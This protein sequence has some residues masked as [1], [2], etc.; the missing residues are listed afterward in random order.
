[1]SSKKTPM[2]TKQTPAAIS[3]VYGE[4]LLPEAAASAKWETV[5]PESRVEMVS[6]QLIHRLSFSHPAELKEEM[7]RFIA[8]IGKEVVE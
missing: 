8:Q 5:S 3:A 2:S 7:E 6:P 4:R 1:M